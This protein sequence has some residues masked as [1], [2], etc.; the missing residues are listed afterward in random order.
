ML[1]AED[2]TPAIKFTDG[3]GGHGGSDVFRWIVRG[4][5][6]QFQHHLPGRRMIAVGGI[7]R[8]VHLLDYLDQGIKEMQIG[9]AYIDNEDPHV[10]SRIRQEYA[11]QLTDME[12]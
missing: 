7:Y 11:D 5:I 3:L 1:R 12:D 4:V 6:I 10:F 8:G 9:T 2:R